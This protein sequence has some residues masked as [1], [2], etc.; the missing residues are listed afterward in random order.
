MK[1][2][3]NSLIQIEQQWL[4]SFFLSVVGMDSRTEADLWED[5]ARR[6]NAGISERARHLQ[7]QVR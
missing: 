4:F 3:A 5:E 2:S 7:Q 6:P 1:I